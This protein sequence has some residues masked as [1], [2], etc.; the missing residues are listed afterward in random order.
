ML[1]CV[2]CKRYLIYCDRSY[3]REGINMKKGLSVLLIA[4]A[5]FGFYGGATSLTDVLASKDYWEEQGEN[6]T[7]DMN[8]LEDGLNQL[9]DNE[10]AYLDGQKQL[11][12]GEKKL[13][14]AEVQLA[15]GE[16]QLA[17][18]RAELAQGYADYAAAPA[19]LAAGR[20]AVAKGE[21][22]LASLGTLI[23][24]I[25]AV[26]GNYPTFK[27]GYKQLRDGRV[28]AIKNP[29]DMSQLVAVLNAYAQYAGD[30]NAKKTLQSLG[31]AQAAFADQD[32][33]SFTNEQYE[34]FKDYLEKTKKALADGNTFLNGVKKNN[35][36]VAGKFT[37]ALNGAKAAA[38]PY[39]TV[40]K[41]GEAYQ[42]AAAE[43]QADPTNPEKKAAYEKAKATYDGAVDKYGTPEQVTNGLNAALAVC[44]GTASDAT[45]ASA[46]TLATNVFIGSKDPAQAQQ[47]L[48]ALSF[49]Q[50]GLTVGADGT[51]ADKV[52]GYLT[53]VGTIPVALS[54]VNEGISGIQ[55][56]LLK[57]AKDNANLWLRGYT[58]LQ[59]AR[60]ASDGLPYLADGVAQIVGGVYDSGNQALIAGMENA[61][62]AVG[63]KPQNFTP[64]ATSQLTKD[65][66]SKAWM[67][68]FYNDGNKVEKAFSAVLPQLKNKQEAGA[69]ELEAGKRTLRQGEADYAAAPAKLAAGEKKLAEGEATLA[70]GYKQYEQG[71]KDLADGKKKLAEYEDGEQQVRDG[72]ATLMATK[73]DPGLESILDRRNGD[74]KFDDAKGH[75]QLDEG[76]EAVDV[77]R[78]YQA[79]SGE[80]ITKEV[81]NRAIGTAAGL[82]AAA[83]A[84]LAAVLSFL[85]KNKGAA[86][87][88]VL[89]AV[90]GGIG[91][92]VGFGAGEYYSDI[93]GS[94]VGNTPFIAAAVLAA[95]A[96]VFAIAHFTAQPEAKS[97]AK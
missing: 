72:L 7:A 58:Q 11:A 16:K 30:A 49:A 59:T 40:M 77:G 45:L 50:G 29:T 57:D 3:L 14:D 73:A 78:G 81:T 2:A 95:V 66:G 68:N 54:G 43:Y 24:G 34:G 25:E 51:N 79:D 22:D 17:D 53:S 55:N 85:K 5:L 41:A 63:F 71:K 92:G 28:D 93:A 20:A 4:A 32:A 96:V 82:G 23:D 9:K 64:V 75:L 6:S 88:A 47:V 97:E 62:S 80:L 10:K 46:V 27:N 26:L 12:D 1:F 86:V 36:T 74:D 67:E 70:D 39:A 89:A 42:K 38:T 52:T 31:V 91:A 94:T 21:S 56:T 13:A 44:A 84:V 65:L 35:N 19:K 18:G 15:D 69:Q 87:S 37:S 83:L 60:T 61:A 90:A 48:N 76:L 33:G 8:K